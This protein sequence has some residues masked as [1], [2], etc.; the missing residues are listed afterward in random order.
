MRSRL[1][2][3][4]VSVDEMSER[5]A[6]ELNIIEPARVGELTGAA[7]KPAAIIAELLAE[8]RRSISI[9]SC[10]NHLISPFTTAWNRPALAQLDVIVLKT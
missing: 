2:A 6:V 1:A 4:F 7:I 10:P 9:V 8:K 3:Y 5:H